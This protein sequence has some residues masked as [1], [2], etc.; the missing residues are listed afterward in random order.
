MLNI[1]QFSAILVKTGLFVKH[2][3]HKYN[4][5]DMISEWF[6]LGQSK[7]RK[8]KPDLQ[9]SSKEL[10]GQLKVSSLAVL[11]TNSLSK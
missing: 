10:V 5:Y 6:Y 3:N 2:F 1:T 7:T 4:D 9:L 8:E 11:Y